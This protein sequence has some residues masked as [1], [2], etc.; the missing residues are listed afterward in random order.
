MEKFISEDSAFVLLVALALLFAGC[1]SESFYKAEKSFNPSVFSQK[2]SP[3]DIF[4]EQGFQW[5]K[6][7][8]I[9]TISDST[10]TESVELKYSAL[11]CFVDEEYIGIV[12]GLRTFDAGWQYLVRPT[13]SDLIVL[14]KQDLSI[15]FKRRIY[16]R[17]SDMKII[18]N[19]LYFKYGKYPNFKYGFY[20]FNGD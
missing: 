1:I 8:N 17:V 12:S 3:I 2:I 6:E 18:E 7:G 19:R 10:K 20:T 13:F 9:V 16:N 5:E 14:N 11:I 15:V 4:G